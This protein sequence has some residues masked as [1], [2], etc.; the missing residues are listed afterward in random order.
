MQYDSFSPILHGT[1]LQTGP[2]HTSRYFA[3]SR[4]S[5]PLG[6]KV[7]APLSAG[8]PAQF[9]C[10]SVLAIEEMYGHFS[11]ECSSSGRTVLYS[12]GVLTCTPLSCQCSL[13]L[14]GTA[15][16][17]AAATSTAQAYLTSS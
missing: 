12:I 7:P 14:Q 4:M 1:A 9:W 5:F 6:L 3:V 8:G 16:W 10:L 13:E 2:A 17:I 15:A 11:N